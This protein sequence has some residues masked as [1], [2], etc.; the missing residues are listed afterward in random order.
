MTFLCDCSYAASQGLTFTSYQNF[1][2]PI[3]HTNSV[4]SSE[5]SLKLAE[6]YT[7][8]ETEEN[9]EIEEDPF[10]EDPFEEDPF[11]DNGSDSA[12]MTDVADPI[13]KWNRLVFQ[14]NDK[15]YT[16]VF[17]PVAK[18]YRYVTPSVIRTGIKNFFTNLLGP[19]RFVNCVLQGKG[20]AADAEAVRFVMNS[21]VGV[22]GFGNPADNYPELSLNY[23]DFGQ[24]FGRWGIGEGF[25]I[26]WPILGPSTL[27]DSFGKVGNFYLTPTTYI[28]PL[29]TNLGIVA[30]DYLNEYSY[31]V[32][33]YESLKEAALDPYEAFRN[34]YIQYQKKQVAK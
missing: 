12:S 5:Y 7:S 29:E 10:E 15:L 14:F 1:N 30:I 3:L 34:F 31:Y 6:N 18:S 28:E 23:E 21:T 9:D 17:F 24:T 13:E 27:R 20:E 2:S 22:L 19:L 16:W 4:Q 32:N 33:D 8:E 11:G 25:Y 26:V